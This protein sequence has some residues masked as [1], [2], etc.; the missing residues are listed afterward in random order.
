MKLVLI[1]A[2]LFGSTPAFA[3][4]P[5][6][7]HSRGSDYGHASYGGDHGYWATRAYQN[8]YYYGDARRGYGTHRGYGYGAY[9]SR[10]ERHH[11]RDHRRLERHEIRNHGY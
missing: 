9:V 8:D 5:R 2:A 10:A 7:D 1:A 3:D 4:P 11:A 6:F